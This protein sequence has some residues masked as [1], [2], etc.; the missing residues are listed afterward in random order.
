MLNRS[1][2]ARGRN[3][4]VASFAS[5]VVVVVIRR[6]RLKPL[7]QAEEFLER[8]V[9]PQA[10][11]RAAKQV[12]VAGED[13]PHLARILDPRMADLQLLER[14]SLAV[15]HAEDVVIGLHEQRH[16]VGKRL[17]ARKP[18]G[19]RVAV[20]AHDGQR[21]WMPSYSRRAIARVFSS[22][23][24]SLSSLSSATRCSPL[25]RVAVISSLSCI[26]AEA[27]LHAPARLN[28]VGHEL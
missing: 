3:S 2:S 18:S 7:R 13:A 6:R 11:G 27:S 1:N 21:S 26:I 16:R 25:S 5:M 17:V 20:R 12:I 22:A 15:Q 19:L 4:G 14:N 24:N 10:R 23:G 9:E 28:K 8:I